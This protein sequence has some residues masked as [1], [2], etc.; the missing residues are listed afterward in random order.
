M[1]ETTLDDFQK[2][3]RSLQDQSAAMFAKYSKVQPHDRL[4]SQIKFNDSLMQLLMEGVAQQGQVV[5]VNFLVDWL[6]K[7][8]LDGYNNSSKDIQP[9]DNRDSLIQYVRTFG[10]LIPKLYE[11]QLGLK[12]EMMDI[13]RM[14]KV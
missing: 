10:I 2:V 9:Q 1:V 8:I 14:K 3:L 7:I 4:I 13:Q 11:S 5:K 6:V 12:V